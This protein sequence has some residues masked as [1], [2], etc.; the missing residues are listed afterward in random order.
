MGTVDSSEA[1]WFGNPEF[2]RVEASENQSGSPDRAS[3]AGKEKAEPGSFRPNRIVQKV[4]LAST[5]NRLGSPNILPPK[6]NPPKS[7]P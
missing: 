5:P 4:S 1:G 6:P 7:T 2:R 3:T